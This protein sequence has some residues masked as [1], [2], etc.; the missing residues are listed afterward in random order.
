MRSKTIIASGLGLLLLA[1]CAKH[2]T[3]PEIPAAEFSLV[4]GPTSGSPASPVEFTARVRVLR[5]DVNSS[6]GCGAAPIQFTL[7]DASGNPVNTTDPCAILPACPSGWGPVPQGSVLEVTF[8]F[9]GV[10][11]PETATQCPAPGTMAP[12]GRYTLRARFIY[13]FPGDAG[14]ASREE[15][16]A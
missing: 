9:A 14:L 4:G 6:I 12:S 13:G 1:G 16:R 8:R 3:R 10:V 7:E 5:P 11:L 15:A 2:T